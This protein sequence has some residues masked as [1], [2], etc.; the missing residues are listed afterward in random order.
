MSTEY[1]RAS[2]EETKTH[3]TTV[4][5][6][7]EVPLGP[8][9]TTRIVPGTNMTLSFSSVAP[10]AEGSVHSHA[11]EQMIVVLSGRI[12]ILLAGKLY[13]LTR[14]DVMWV[15]GDV[16]HSGIGL[17]EP[18]EMLE[19]FTPARKDFENKLRQAEGR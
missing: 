18:C 19:I 7:P 1:P 17:D 16:E 6:V 5:Q 11:H 10:H 9:I 2:Q 14:G 13:R 8:K 15:P 12:D 4:G 3:V